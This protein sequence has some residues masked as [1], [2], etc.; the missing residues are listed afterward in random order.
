MEKAESLNKRLYKLLLIYIRYIPAVLAIGDFVNT[1]MSEFEIELPVLSYSTGISFIPLIGYYLISII[2]KF[3]IYH[4]LFLHYV[5][6][7]NIICLY[8][9]EVGIPLDDRSMFSLYLIITFIFTA[10]IIIT[11]VKHHKRITTKNSG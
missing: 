8:D 11:Y 1:L 9:Y 5:T 7:N 6:L 10:L 4:R 3:C 2:L